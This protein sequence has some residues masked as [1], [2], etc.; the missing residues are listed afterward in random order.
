[1]KRGGLFRQTVAVR[2]EQKFTPPWPVTFW[3]VLP[4]PVTFGM[5]MEVS[6]VL[7]ETPFETVHPVDQ[8]ILRAR[9][10]ILT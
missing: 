5:V 9:S 6:L 8:G 2:G 3:V 1:M 4:K 7:F 10:G